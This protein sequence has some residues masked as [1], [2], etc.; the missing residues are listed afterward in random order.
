MA[1]RLYWGVEVGGESREYRQ[2]DIYRS[3]GAR[4]FLIDAPLACPSLLFSLFAIHFFFFFFWQ[5]MHYAQ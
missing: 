4:L 1:W 3:Y 2:G 5:Q